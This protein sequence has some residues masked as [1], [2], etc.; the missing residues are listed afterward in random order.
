ETGAARDQLDLFDDL[1]RR[2]V[3]FHAKSSLRRVYRAGAAHELDAAGRLAGVSRAEVERADRRIDLDRVEIVAAERLDADD[4]AIA[5]RRRFLHQRHAVDAELHVAAR[6]GAGERGLVLVAH[7]SRAG[8]A[9]V[10]LDEDRIAEAARGLDGE[11]R[12]IDRPRRRVG[13]AELLEQ[14]ELRGF[15]ELE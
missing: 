13:Q 10:R 6:H 9:D 1:A 4:V 3:A 11:A 15:R 5:E 12:V 8:A 2:R 7:D 14:I